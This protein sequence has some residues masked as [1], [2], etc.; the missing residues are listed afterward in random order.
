ML[1]RIRNARFHQVGWFGTAKNF[2][3]DSPAEDLLGGLFTALNL[4]LKET[5]QSQQ[6]LETISFGDKVIHVA[7]GQNVTS[8]LITSEQTLITTALSQHLTRHFESQFKTILA[9]STSEK[10]NTTNFEPFFNRDFS[11]QTIFYLL[12][13]S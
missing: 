4:S 2:T 10:L 7:H 8:F 1:R 3:P 11:C 12:T 5:L 9:S 6:D 13:C